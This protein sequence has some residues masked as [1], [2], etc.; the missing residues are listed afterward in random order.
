MNAKEIEKLASI[1]QL[2]GGRV[3]SVFTRQL[4]LLSPSD[5]EKVW[6]KV[7]SKRKNPPKQ[8]QKRLQPERPIGLTWFR[9]CGKTVRTPFCPTCGKGRAKADRRDVCLRLRDDEF[10]LMRL[11]AIN[12]NLPTRYDALKELVPIVEQLTAVD[13]PRICRRPLRI[14]VPV[15]L[16]IAINTKADEINAMPP[17]HPSHQLSDVTYLQIITTAAR[18]FVEKLK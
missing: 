10:D 6:A 9:C 13:L 5:R 4:N 18:K 1:Y 11:I 2:P 17:N 8:K 12:A 15:E 16:D 7:G 14:R 3:N